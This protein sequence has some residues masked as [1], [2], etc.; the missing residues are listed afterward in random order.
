MDTNLDEWRYSGVDGEWVKMAEIRK[1]PIFADYW[2]SINNCEF[3]HKNRIGYWKSRICYWK[4]TESFWMKIRF[5]WKENPFRSIRK[6]FHWKRQRCYLK[7]ERVHYKS[8]VVCWKTEIGFWIK[9]RFFQNKKGCFYRNGF[10][11]EQV[12]CFF[13]SQAF[14]VKYQL[15]FFELQQY[16]LEWNEFI[17]QKQFPPSSFHWP[18]SNFHHGSSRVGAGYNWCHCEP[19]RISRPAWTYRPIP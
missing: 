18:F 12:A 15:L 6:T 11:L 3:D 5:Y 8:K 4:E 1:C 14:S 17:F 10:F 19:I 9:W 2:L 16:F 13:E 7:S